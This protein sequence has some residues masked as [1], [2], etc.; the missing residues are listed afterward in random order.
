MAAKVCEI[1][2]ALD[3]CGCELLESPESAGERV[4]LAS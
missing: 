3:L 1:L 4:A 2:V